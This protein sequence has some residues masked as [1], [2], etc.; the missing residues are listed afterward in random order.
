MGIRYTTEPKPMRTH[1]R[2]FFLFLQFFFLFFL[3][4][5]VLFSVSGLYVVLSRCARTITRDVLT[6]SHS[7]NV[8][9][10]MMSTCVSFRIT[11]SQTLI[12]PTPLVGRLLLFFFLF[13]CYA[14]ASFC[15]VCCQFVFFPLFHV[16]Q[17]CKWNI[18]ERR[19]KKQQ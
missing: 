12:F 14:F 19:R 15:S 18:K 16:K 4:L 7:N 17:R 13:F 9:C 10:L 1:A 6:Y 2:T 8:N 5:F 11:F 3:L